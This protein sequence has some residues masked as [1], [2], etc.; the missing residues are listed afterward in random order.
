AGRGQCTPVGVTGC[1]TRASFP[2]FG[3]SDNG[4]IVFFVVASRSAYWPDE[5]AIAAEPPIA[6]EALAGSFGRQKPTFVLDHG[7]S[8]AHCARFSGGSS[9]LR[10]PYLCYRRIR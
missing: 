3:R 6:L 8:V 7:G 1:R 10:W 4:V 9:G 5:P 2:K